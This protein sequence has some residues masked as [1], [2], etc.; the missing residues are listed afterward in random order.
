MTPLP[1]H[2][3]TSDVAYKYTG[4]ERD[5]TTTDLYFYEARYYDPV[6]GRFI[7]P[8]TIVPSPTDPQ[9]LNR[10]SY[11]VNNPII[12]TDPSGHSFFGIEFVIGA[13]IGAVAGGVSPGIQSDGDI[14]AIFTGIAIGG[15]AGGVGGGTGISAKLNFSYFPRNE[16]HDPF[17][18]VVF[19]GFP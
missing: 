6:L 8:D 18:F 1:T 19:S 5:T 14:G 17:V 9:A 2:T 7:S 13:I 4:K 15:I 12:Y 16:M 3:G 10:F 11:V